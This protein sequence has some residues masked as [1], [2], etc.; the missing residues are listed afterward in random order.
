MDTRTAPIIMSPEVRSERSVDT[1]APSRSTTETISTPTRSAGRRPL[2]VKLRSATT[3]AVPPHHPCVNRRPLPIF[4]FLNR[5]WARSQN[6]AHGVEDSRGVKVTIRTHET[7]RRIGRKLLSAGRERRY[8]GRDGYGSGSRKP[9]PR[10]ASANDAQGIPSTRRIASRAYQ[11]VVD[12]FVPCR[13]IRRS[14][15]NADDHESKCRH[16]RRHLK[17]DHG[18]MPFAE[19]K[20]ATDRRSQSTPKAE[21]LSFIVEDRHRQDT[22]Q[23]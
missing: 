1:I 13:P 18:T 21:L 5:G 2:P 19:A 3:T 9:T 6:T 14:H 22:A 17:P 7:E 16:E 11:W 23:G 4:A 10:Q 20:D 15:P 12:P 8:S